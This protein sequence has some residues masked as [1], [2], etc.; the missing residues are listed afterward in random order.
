MVAAHLLKTGLTFGII[1]SRASHPDCL[2]EQESPFLP[3]IQ[4]SHY[5][6]RRLPQPR[7][8]MNEKTIAFPR[9]R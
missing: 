9:F 5:S 4:T 2:P 6:L 3:L 1:N 8:D 7:Q